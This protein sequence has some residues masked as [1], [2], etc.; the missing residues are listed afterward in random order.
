M[1]LVG[2]NWMERG[3]C[4]KGKEVVEEGVRNEEA[5]FDWDVEG[6][7]NIM[8]ANELIL[9]GK[10]WAS[11]NINARAAI[12]TMLRIWNPVGKV[13]GNVLDAKE[14]IFVFRFTDERDKLKEPNL[15]GKMTDIPFFYLPIWARI[16]DLPLNSRLNEGNLRRLGEQLGKFM[17]VDEVVC[18]EIESAV[19]VRI[20]HDVRKPLHASTDIRLPSGKITSFVVKYERL[21][22]FCYG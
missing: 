22:M 1:G 14:R 16:Y 4:S 12:D 19:R 6:E 13:M 7:E 2:N 15:E 11:K 9:V 21:P 10:I 20:L 17:A 18:P 3:A 5:D 8:G